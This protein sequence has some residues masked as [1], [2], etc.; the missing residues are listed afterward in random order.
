MMR[1]ARNQGEREKQRADF[2]FCKN[3]CAWN[4]FDSKQQNQYSAVAKLI[5]DLKITFL[6]TFTA[7]DGRSNL[8]S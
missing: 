4:G 5:I 1:T 7:F 2:C 8:I 6:P 3:D